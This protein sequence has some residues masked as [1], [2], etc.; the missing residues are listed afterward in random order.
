VRK[1]FLIFVA[2]GLV[3]C[4]AVDAPEVTSCEQYVQ[5]KLRSPSTYKRVST[6]TVRLADK[7]GPYQSV[8]IEYDAVNAYNAPL[9]D[10]QL[11]RFPIKDD[12]P[13]T[14]DYIDHDA[15]LLDSVLKSGDNMTAVTGA[16]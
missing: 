6:A 7:G 15:A 10:R 14:S 11:C 5:A 9:R 1:R 3:S 12:R 13:D 16:E 2:T 8:M 4:S